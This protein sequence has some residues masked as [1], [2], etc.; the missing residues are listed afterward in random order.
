VS[1]G[2][3]YK[4]LPSYAPFDSIIV[5]WSCFIPQPLMAQLKWVG[6]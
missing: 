2:D 6:L 1:F 5:S 4:G 3:G